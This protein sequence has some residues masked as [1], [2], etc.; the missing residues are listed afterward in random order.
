MRLYPDRPWVG[1]GIVIHKDDDILLIK[2]AKPPYA[3]QWSLPG[4]A[5]DLGETIFQGAYREALEETNIKTTDHRLIDI[6]DSIHKDENDKIEYH[7][8]LIEVSC[9][10][11]SGTLKAMDDA[12][13]AQWV[14]FTKIGN[15]GLRDE[16]L[17]IITQSYLSRNASETEE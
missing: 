16:T 9:L 2:R 15:Y 4:G 6:V 13:A 11:K 12:S 3:G 8:T 5:Q 10:Y 7:Y 17:R 1:I 14:P